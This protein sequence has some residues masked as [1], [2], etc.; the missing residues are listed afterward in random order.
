MA[1]DAFHSTKM[2][3]TNGKLIWSPD[4]SGDR[5][6]SFSALPSAFRRIGADSIDHADDGIAGGVHRG[7]NFG[8][9]TGENGCP[10]CCAFFSLN[11]LHFVAVRIRLNL[12]PTG[13]DLAPPRPADA[14]SPAR[15]F[16]R[17]S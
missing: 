11:N 10:V 5:L 8:D 4:K 3:L 13:N 12:A 15:S 1:S 17:K 14:F 7:P 6:H 9:D 2:H 16:L